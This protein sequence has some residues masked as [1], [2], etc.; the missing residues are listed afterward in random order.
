MICCGVAMVLLSSMQTNVVLILV[1]RSLLQLAM[2]WHVVTSMMPL[3]V[4]TIC[5]FPSSDLPKD[6]PSNHVPY[7]SGD[8]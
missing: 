2:G 6:I 7:V 1:I 5:L 3:A 8:C 4:I